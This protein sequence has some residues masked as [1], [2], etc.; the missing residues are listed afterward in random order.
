[1][2]DNILYFGTQ[3]G[4]CAPIYISVLL[5]LLFLENIYTNNVIFYILLS[6]CCTDSLFLDLSHVSA[7]SPTEPPCS[8]RL[9][10]GLVWC[11]PTA[12]PHQISQRSRG[13]HEK[14]WW[15][16]ALGGSGLPAVLQSQDRIFLPGKAGAEEPI[17]RGCLA[18]RLP[19]ETHA[20]QGE[21]ETVICHCANKMLFWY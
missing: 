13:G 11:S 1:M 21:D 8:W 20:R 10:Q 2:L 18:Q 16:T 9:L 4:D 3:C 6:C 12:R 15:R 19:E 14:I 5:T 17:S 7:F